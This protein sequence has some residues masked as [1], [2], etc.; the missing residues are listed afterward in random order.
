MD[1]DLAMLLVA[2]AGGGGWGGGALISIREIWKQSFILRILGTCSST[3]S[4]IH[5]LHR[6]KGLLLL[7]LLFYYSD[8][9]KQGSSYYVMYGV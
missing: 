9:K 3:E 5:S 6:K 7:L 8:E 1:N 2:R 4:R